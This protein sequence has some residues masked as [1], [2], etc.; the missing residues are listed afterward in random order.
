MTKVHA[1]FGHLVPF[2]HAEDEEANHGVDP[3]AGW[4][5]RELISKL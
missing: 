5:T 4:L 1:V 3:E 2:R